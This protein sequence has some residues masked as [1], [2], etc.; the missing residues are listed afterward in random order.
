MMRPGLGAVCLLGW[1][2]VAA[3]AAAQ[4][5]APFSGQATGHVGVATGT[6]GRGSTLSL[7]ASVAM[8]S[9]GGW[10]AEVDVGFADDDN[11]RSGGLDVQSYMLNVIGMWPTGSLRPFVVAG[12]GVLR[13]RTCTPA[14]ANTLA[15]T[16]W[17][18][19]GGAGVLYQLNASAALRGDVRYFTAPGDHP[20]PLRPDRFSFWR[21]SFG[22]TFLWTE[23]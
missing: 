5:M 17:G 14:C 21:V 2:M 7:G 1:L 23:E 4:G 8:I 10:G 20:D 6:D 13:A 9:V 3:P 19:S 11:G 16:D 22:A 15:W 12:G 18:L